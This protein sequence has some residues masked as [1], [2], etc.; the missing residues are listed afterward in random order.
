[1]S[2][3]TE[4]EGRVAVIERLLPGIPF[5]QALTTAQGEERR[6][7]LLDYL[8]AASQIGDI[9]VKR[10]FFGDL[11]LE[12]AI[13]RPSYQGYLS[14]RLALTRSLPGPLSHLPTD[15]LAGI[16]DCSAG[17]LV[18]FDIFPGNVL[19]DADHVTAVIDFGATSMIADRRLDCWSA[20]AYLDSG[21]VAGGEC[22]RPRSGSRLA[23]AAWARRRLR[24]RQT[25]D[26]Q[27]L[28]FCP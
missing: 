5:S 28:V 7:L 22:A 8:D 6:Q 1:M 18:H 13:R 24:R 16:P 25:L 14:A 15:N 20:V 21:I 23:G 11:G 19:V 3:I 9:A 27:L 10:D 2:R 26:R 17:A 12:R 4:I